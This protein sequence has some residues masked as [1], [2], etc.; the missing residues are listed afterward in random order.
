MTTDA[1]GVP[2][3]DCI[4]PGKCAPSPAT[5]ILE[6]RNPTCDI[7][8]YQGGQWAC[9]HM[10]SLLDK[11]QPIPWADQPLVFQ[12]K[13]AK[14]PS[15]ATA[16]PFIP[17]PLHFNSPLLDSKAPCSAFLHQSPLSRARP[18]VAFLGSAVRPELPHGAYAGGVSGLCDLARLAVGIRCPPVWAGRARVLMGM[19]HGEPGLHLGPHGHWKPHGPAHLCRIQSPVRVKRPRT[20]T[21]LCYGGSPADQLPN[22]RGGGFA[23]RLRCTLSW[24]SPYLRT[25]TG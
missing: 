13:C 21:G 14:V 3:A 24:A 25:R 7:R 15:N 18:Q 12:H 2:L 5:T 22:L 19:W 8:N 23:H 9:H 20:H 10:W 17:N 4:S 11:E 6:Q 16:R 1:H